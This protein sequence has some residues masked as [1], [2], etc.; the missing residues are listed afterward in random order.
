[1]SSERISYIELLTLNNEL[2]K[3][4]LGDKYNVTVLSNIVVNQLKEI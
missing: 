4:I 1:M 3:N 2:K